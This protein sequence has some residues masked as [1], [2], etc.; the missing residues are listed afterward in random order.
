[1]LNNIQKISLIAALLVSSAAMASVTTTYGHFGANN[2]VTDTG[3]NFNQFDVTLGGVDINV[4]AWSDTGNM[5]GEDTSVAGDNKIER[6]V[7]MDQY[8]NGWSIQ[9]ADEQKTDGSKLNYCGYSHSADNYGSSCEY[10]DYDFFLLDFSEAVTLNA[11]GFSWISASTS[12]T[13]VSVAALNSGDLAGKT[14]AQVGSSSQTIA[15]G[16]A[17]M[18][19]DNNYGYYTMFGD[20]DKN[21][22]GSIENASSRYWLVGALNAAVFGGDTTWEGNDGIK[23]SGIKFTTSQQAP[24]T[25]VPEPSSI[26]LFG[27]AIAGL[28]ASS[29][30]KLK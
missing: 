4:S 22:L 5:P 9:N 25:S 3:N 6:A 10:Q 20:S 17:Q 29:R 11:A 23:L 16:Y 30:K 12:N 15:S 8:G 19:Y 26:A 18:Q 21:K 14:W 1:M 27:L 2:G 28:F 13:E 7:D 24:A